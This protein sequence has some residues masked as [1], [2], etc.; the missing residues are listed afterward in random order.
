MILIWQYSLPGPSGFNTIQTNA[1]V[2]DLKVS[3]AKTS[4]NSFTMFS[5]H[6]QLTRN[7]T[8]KSSYKN[9]TKNNSLRLV[10]LKVKTEIFNNCTIKSKAVR[11]FEISSDSDVCI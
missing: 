6:Q 1:V 2:I 4:Y 8:I 3:K 9:T 11:F 5:L 10:T 7:V